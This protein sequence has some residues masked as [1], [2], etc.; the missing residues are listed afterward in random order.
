M[1][2][3]SGDFSGVIRSDLWGAYGDVRG[4]WHDVM[5]AS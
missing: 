1:E 5:A 4:D 3:W 2:W